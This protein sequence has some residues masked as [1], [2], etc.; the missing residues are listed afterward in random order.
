MDAKSLN[1]AHRFVL[2]VH[3]LQSSVKPGLKVKAEYICLGITAIFIHRSGQASILVLSLKGLKWVAQQ[4]NRPVRPQ[5][6]GEGDRHKFFHWLRKMLSQL[7]TNSGILQE[8]EGMSLS[9]FTMKR[10]LKLRSESNFD[11]N[12]PHHLSDMVEVM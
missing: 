10:P 11:L 9:T 4:H 1:A 3:L 8:E 5:K 7:L 2:F 6:T 12:L